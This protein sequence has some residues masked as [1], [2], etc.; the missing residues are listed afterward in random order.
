MKKRFLPF[1]FFAFYVGFS[2]LFCSSLSTAGKPGDDLAKKSV[3]GKSGYTIDRLTQIRNNQV[4]G[5]VD[6]IDLLKAQQQV[7]KLSGNKHSSPLNLQWTPIGPNN[8][9]GR[10]RALIFDNKDANFKTL[11]TGGVAG[12][13]WKSSN[14]GLTWDQVNTQ[15]NEVLRVTS[16]TQ[17]PSGT[18]YVGTGETYCGTDGFVGTGLYRS[19][20]GNLFTPVAGTQ[21]SADDT[22]S[23][24]AFITKLACSSTGRIFAATNTGLF[25]SDNGTV[26][27]NAIPGFAIDVKVG[28]DGTVAAAVDKKVYIA[29]TGDVANFVNV[30]TGSPN[31]PTT[32]VGWVEL[33]IAPSD[34]NIIYAS[35]AMLDT[36]KL[37]NVY[38]SEDK[39]VSWRVIFP[40]NVNINPLGTNGCYANTLVV[41]PENP[42]KVL[43]GGVDMWVGEKFTTTGYYNWEEV[44]TYASVPID[45]AF[46]PN[47]HHAYVFKPN[48]PSQVAIATDDGISLGTITATG[49]SFQ[50]L[51]KNLMVS[52]FNSVAFSRSRTAVLGG[53]VTIGTQ[54]IPGG[55]VL[56]EPM[57]GVR[58]DGY[59]YG[60]GEDC[61]W[62]LINPNVIVYTIPPSQRPASPDDAAPPLI[63]SEDMGV[64]P[65]P[66]FLGGVPTAPYPPDFFSI[67]NWESFNYGYSRDS[68]TYYAT[69][70][71]IPADSTIIVNSSNAKFP[72][73]YT[74]PV[75]IPLG[76][77][78]RVQDV[79]QSRFFL[80]N[81]KDT[82][83]IFMTKD[84][85]KFAIDPKWFKIA[86]VDGKDPITCMDV[87]KDL[88]V[89]WAGTKNGKLFRVSNL[90][91]ANDSATADISS[92]TCI[93]STQRL[94]NPLFSNRYVT[95]ISIA[96]DNSTVLVTLGNYNNSEYVYLTTNG[97][98]SLP[99]FHSVQGSLPAMPVLSSVMEM[100]DP[101]R[102]I[103]GTD[104]GIFSTD[105]ISASS[106]DW[107]YESAG[108]G[109]VPVVKLKQ[110]TNEGTYYYHMNN[111]GIIYSATYGS[112]LFIDTTYFTPLGIKPV[113]GSPLTS[114]QLNIYPNPATQSINI[115][116]KLEKSSD[117]N[118]LVYDM[119]GKVVFTKSLGRK[120]VG[121]HTES[122]DLSSVSS[123]TFLVR[124]AYGNGNAFGKVIK[125]N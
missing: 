85:L 45:P 112:G 74:T 58:I 55:N 118:I 107:Q 11:Y 21:P 60:S 25:Y 67:Y 89:L 23:S 66:T 100:N 49:F 8:E 69:T 87:S 31:L 98:D 17:T 124:L 59:L 36:K 20:D 105:N 93:V 113:N 64:T 84:L 47:F 6:P 70:R 97:L 75:P 122:I 72:M 42:F 14:L 88:T 114:N 108:I 62:S 106:P 115:S 94:V 92:S 68:V 61:A 1:G 18:I 73:R 10:I 123:G 16:M 65:S 95:S 7:E 39:G 82:S 103:L 26:W 63:R 28:S 91:L 71:N 99:I 24:W 117:I 90:Q 120:Q 102:V 5:K 119:T 96:P 35:L 101:N 29:A 40:N 37:L 12:G 27:T 34:P 33:A 22:T 30:S 48:N 80:G 121:N 76:D 79:V 81:V 109:N 110:Q 3:P 57:N 4:T 86:K 52:Q 56:N 38:C 13:I 46:V 9:A 125:V 2:I 51:I 19:E 15:N 41:Y 104:F 44:S 53:A 54:F 77:S 78:I 83:G 32:N 111:Y 116:Y 50:Q 43:L